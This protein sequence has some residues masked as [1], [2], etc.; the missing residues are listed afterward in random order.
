VDT[1][2]LYAIAQV[3]VAFAGFSGIAVVLRRSEPGGLSPHARRT[4]GYLGGEDA[5]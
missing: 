1:E 4:L 5:E 3:A 2:L